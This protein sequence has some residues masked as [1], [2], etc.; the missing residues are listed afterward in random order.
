MKLVSEDI[1]LDVAIEPQSIVGDSTTAFFDM[2]HYGRALFVVQLGAMADAVT[3]AMQARQDVSEAGTTAKDITNAAAIA[4]SCT[5]VTSAKLT[6]D[7]CDVGD[8]CTINGL[9]FTGAAA[10]SLKDRKFAA[11]N[12][13]NKETGESLAK[14][15]ND[16]TYGVPGVTA[17][18][19]AN[20]VVTLTATLP[21][22]TDITVT[23]TAIKLVPATLSALAY[24]EVDSA[25][26]DHANGCDHVA[27]KITNSAAT[28]TS[29]LLLRGAGRYTPDQHVAA[30]KVDVKP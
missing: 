25:H 30:A 22:E 9:T 18:A 14:A 2:S 21:G 19:D 23:G 7:G 11:D 5:K 16:A 10:E 29:V 20:G 3:C 1:K 28:I 15:I 6:V 4:T 26:L 17:A 13:K 8:T 24:V 12:T 27:L